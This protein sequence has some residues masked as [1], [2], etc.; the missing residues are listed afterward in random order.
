MSI[1]LCTWVLIIVPRLVCRADTGWEWCRIPRGSIV[2]VAGLQTRGTGVYVR[3]LEYETE[4]RS[5]ARPAVDKNLAFVQ[6]KFLAAVASLQGQGIYATDEERERQLQDF[7]E[8]YRA[9]PDLL[10]YFYAY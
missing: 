3:C 8:G 7:H 10:M 5:F 9:P 2:G 6:F 1:T 4:H